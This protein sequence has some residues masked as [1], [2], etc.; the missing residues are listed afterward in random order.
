M[1]GAV[2]MCAIV[3]SKTKSGICVLVI[4][5]MLNM[6]LVLLPILPDA[7]DYTYT[8]FAVLYF[9]IMLVFMYFMP[10]KLNFE[11]SNKLKHV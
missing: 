11:S 2:G 5:S 4:Q 3:Y 9:L 1:M 8:I 6:S 10:P 7:G